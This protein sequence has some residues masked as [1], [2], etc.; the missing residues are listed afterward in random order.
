MTRK[1]A[2]KVFSTHPAMKAEDNRPTKPAFAKVTIRE[3]ANLFVCTLVLVLIGATSTHY[4]IVATLWLPASIAAI[5]ACGRS[6][7]R[8]RRS[9]ADHVL[10]YSSASLR[11]F[12]WTYVAILVVG[13]FSMAPPV[14][15]RSVV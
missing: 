4:L 12:L 9:I 15:M 3:I 6:S 10:A 7:V 5:A 1:Y 11:L 14:I 8:R 2:R 13:R